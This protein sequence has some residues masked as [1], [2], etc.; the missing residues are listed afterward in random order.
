MTSGFFPTPYP[1]ECLYSILCRY[2]AR[3]GGT[4]YEVVCKMLF[5]GLQTLMGTIYLPVKS[6]RIDY[7]ASPESG[8][9]RSSIAASNTMHP[10]F[11]ISYTPEL[12]TEIDRV[13]NGGVPSLT[14]DRKMALKSWRS[15][16]QHLRYCPSCVAEDIAVYGETYWHRRHQLPG[17]YYCT[18]HQI[19]LVNSH[20]TTKQTTAGFYPASD[21]ARVDVADVFGNV[22]YN[23]RDKC[24]KIGR[25][26][27]WLLE[28]GLS[29]DWQENGRNK[30]LRLFRDRGIASV[31]GVRCDSEALRNAVSDYWGREFIDA[32][33]SETPVYHEWLSRIHDCMM[34]RFL[35]LQHI[36]L[37]CVAKES[38]DE[39]VKCGVSENPFGIGPF[40]CE[41]PICTHY[42]IDGAACTEVQRFNSRAVGHFYCKDCGMHYK[43]SKAKALKGVIVITDYGHLWKNTLI[44][45]SKDKTITN[46]KAAEMLKC[47]IS[48]M[49]LQKKKLG[50]LRT[51]PYDAEYGPEA[52]YKAKV[53][54]LIEDYGE[55]T[56]SLM[57]DKAPGAYD[58]L[59]KFHNKWLR[60]HQTLRHETTRERARTEYV[61]KKA[62]N[63]VEKIAS[64]I[65]ERQISYGYIAKVAGLTRN[66][67]RSNSQVRACVE[68]IVESRKDWH[69]RRIKA[70]YLSLPFKGR[71]YAVVDVCRVASISMKTY[72]KYHEQFEEV[73]KDL[74][75]IETTI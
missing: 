46:E 52:Y 44:N 42:H 9:T 43:I 54:A 2:Y 29:V 75:A 14:H 32:L 39:F 20:V 59:R 48:V 21:E 55:V 45:Y 3:C 24:L 18:K 68:D 1:D 62:Q 50:L 51:L 37:M 74:N 28:N 26:S 67:L 41:N 58:Y 33:F 34:S 35:P 40:V 17:Y 69:L 71:P 73:V 63:A 5:G 65:P 57:Q 8:I 23:Y 13:L 16:V 10:Y 15:W 6:E 61:H 53:V 11:A 70:A 7:W 56:F 12:R 19:R 31:H 38:V 30:Y 72:V 25:E 36:L 66:S 60:E 27:E 64:C 47:D 22:F 49:M 4:S